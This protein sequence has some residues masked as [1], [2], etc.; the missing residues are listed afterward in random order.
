MVYIPEQVT[1]ILA[2]L[3]SAAEESAKWDHYFK[4]MNLAM[5]E[6]D[7]IQANRAYDNLTTLIKL[8]PF[9]WC[10]MNAFEN[11]FIDVGELGG[12]ICCTFHD[13]TILA[14][15]H[16]AIPDEINQIIVDYFWGCE[17]EESKHRAD[18]VLD[19]ISS[20]SLK[21]KTASGSSPGA[22]WSI[23]YGSAPSKS[24]TES[25]ATSDDVIKPQ[26]RDGGRTIVSAGGTFTFTRTQGEVISLLWDNYVN[27]NEFV[28]EQELLNRVDRSSSTL[29]NLF[30]SRHSEF[31][32]I[33]ERNPKAKD[34]IRLRVK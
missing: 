9:R 25:R 33:T 3:R 1:E 5:D 23:S 17:G 31:R 14:A 22:K 4:S 24:G 16:C 21:L 12:R 32:A 8:L 29:K 30:R 27:G 13:K 18:N 28:D 20:L 10:E 6:H 26:I 2:E 7:A 19:L 34:M 11:E 15:V